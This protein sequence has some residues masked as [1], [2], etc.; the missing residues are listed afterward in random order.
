MNVHFRI[1]ITH[2]PNKDTTDE[3][4]TLHPTQSETSVHGRV[5]TRFD[6]LVEHCI[7]NGYDLVTTLI[8]ED[9]QGNK[10]HQPVIKHFESYLE[11][12]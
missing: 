2:L 12:K 5:N 1:R 11:Q 9:S 6:Q 7:N 8:I 4:V 3:Y 10:S